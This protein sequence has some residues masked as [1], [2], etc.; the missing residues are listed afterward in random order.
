MFSE[1]FKTIVSYRDEI[2]IFDNSY[3]AKEFCINEL[4]CAVEAW[5][6]DEEAFNYYMKNGSHDFTLNNERIHS[7]PYPNKFMNGRKEQTICFS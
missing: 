5:D 4:T 7:R 2:T 1:Y 3:K 6:C